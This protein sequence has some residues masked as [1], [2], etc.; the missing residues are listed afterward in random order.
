MSL[1]RKDI[2]AKLDPDMYEAF[3]QIASLEGLQLCDL[4]ERELVAFIARRVH[5]ARLLAAGTTR[6]RI[7]GNFREFQGVLP[8]TPPPDESNTR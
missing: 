1:P 3:A 6:L 8:L 5:D 4:L 2:R 7:T